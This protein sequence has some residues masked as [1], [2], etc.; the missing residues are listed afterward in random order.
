MKRLLKKTAATALSMVGILS[1]MPSVFCAPGE[2]P[3]KLNERG[4]LDPFHAMIVGKYFD[5]IEDFCNLAIVNNVKYGN[6][7][8]NYHFNPIEIN[9]KKEL[10][11]LPSI[12]TYHAETFKKRNFVYTFPDSQIKTLIYFPGSFDSLKL[13]RI[14]KENGIIDKNKNYNE[15]WDH[16]LEINGGNP[17]N[18]CRFVFKSGDKEIIFLFEPSV[19][20]RLTSFESYNLLL[21]K[22]HDLLG[23]SHSKK[24]FKLSEVTIN[25]PAKFSIPDYVTSIGE[26]AFHN[27]TSLTNVALPNSVKN[28]GKQAFQSCINLKEI[29]IPEAVTIIGEEAFSNCKTLKKI[30][31]PHSAA[32]IDRCAFNGCTSLSS[33]DIPDSVKSIEEGAFY[34]C[35]SLTNIKIPN[36]I[37]SIGNSAFSACFG[38]T[39]IDIPDSVVSIGE[40]AFN[41]CESLEEVNISNS[42]TSI[43]N[44]VFNYCP[45]LDNVVIPYSVTS[46]GEG[47]FSYCER[48]TNIIIP[49]SVTSMGASVF[50]DCKHLTNITIPHSVTSIGE[51][52]FSGCERLTYINIPNSVKSIGEGLFEGC[53]NLNHIEFNGE[54]YKSEDSF[55]KAFKDCKEK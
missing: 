2:E 37:K 35:C 40:G 24:N 32:S 38:L 8:G 13:E 11:I 26:K 9:F 33:V 34:G 53:T 41:C 6:M 17:M 30:S 5:N 43:G 28:I 51:N 45:W 48:L 25:L 49:N 36:S 14:L 4:R 39:K 1:T 21:K 29:T 55:M 12:E 23:N 19:V 54:V 18:G 44:N 27:C 50:S 15:K 47:A 52:A 46:I 20:G 31:L 7:L 10:A 3:E 42:V 22:L 16:Q